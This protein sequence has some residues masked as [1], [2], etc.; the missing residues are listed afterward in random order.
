MDTGTYWHFMHMNKNMD[1][2]KKLI[3]LGKIDIKY[4]N[5]YPIVGYRMK[6]NFKKN[7][8]E[9]AAMVYQLEW[10][11]MLTWHYRAAMNERRDLVQMWDSLTF[12][13]GPQM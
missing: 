12:P 7:K 1:K 10:P 2:T 3:T 4:G 5:T 13:T 11:K 6:R 8:T 9:A